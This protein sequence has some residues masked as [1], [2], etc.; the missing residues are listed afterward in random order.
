MITQDIT[1]VKEVD[2][3]EDFMVFYNRT[4]QKLPKKSLV[5]LAFHYNFVHE[6]LVVFKQSEWAKTILQPGYSYS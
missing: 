2:D 1:K 6:Y 5:E 4:L 3:C